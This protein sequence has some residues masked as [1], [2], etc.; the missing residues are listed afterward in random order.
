MV[1]S[2]PGCH[3]LLGILQVQEPVLV[4]ALLPEPSVER[5]DEGVVRGLP[6]LVEVQLYLET[7]SKLWKAMQVGGYALNR[8]VLVREGKHAGREI[9]RHLVGDTG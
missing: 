7:I 9:A 5:L 1:M 6:G 3:L 2:A 4:Q 8:D